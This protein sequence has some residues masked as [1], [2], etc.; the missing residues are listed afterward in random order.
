MIKDLGRLVEGIDDLLL[1][2]LLTIY[3]VL[4]L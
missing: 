1:A 2:W 3:F 4:S